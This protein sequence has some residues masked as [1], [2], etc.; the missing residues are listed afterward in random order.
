MMVTMRI[1][2]H[3]LQVSIIAIAMV[4]NGQLLLVVV[5]VERHFMSM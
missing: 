5:Q 1:Q 3:L 2:H 4:G